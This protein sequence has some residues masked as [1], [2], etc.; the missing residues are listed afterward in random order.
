MRISFIK[1]D[2]QEER[3]EGPFFGGPET[4]THEDEIDESLDRAEAMILN[5]LDK[6]L[7]EGS[8]WQIDEI[9]GHYINLVAFK[10]LEGSSWLPSP[11]ELQNSAKGVINIKNDDNECLRWAH[12]RHLNPQAKN[13][14]R[15]K[16]SD[17]KMIDQLDYSGIQFPVQIKDI[18]RIEKQNKIRINVFGY[19]D[20]TTFPVS[21]S[22]EQFEDTLNLLLLVDGEKQHYALI[23]DFNRFMYQKTKHKA[24]KHFCENCLQNFTTG[25]QLQEHQTQ[26]KQ[27]QAVKMPDPSKGEHLLKFD[28]Y[29]RQVA[30]PFVIYCDTE[31][32]LE[33]IEQEKQNDDQSFTEAYQKHK[34]CGFGYKVACFYYDKYSKPVQIN[35]GNDAGKRFIRELHDEVQT[36]VKIATMLTEHYSKTE[37]HDKESVFCTNECVV[38]GNKFKKQENRGSWFC[39]FTGKCKGTAHRSCMSKAW[40]DPKK[41][42]IPIVFHNLKGYDSHFIIQ[43]LGNFINKQKNM[44]VSVIPNNT[45]KYMAFSLG[46]HMVFI[47][48]FQFMSSSLDKLV[49]N[50]PKDALK[51]TSQVFGDL[52]LELMTRKGVYPYDYMDSFEKFKEKKIP[53][54][55]AFYSQ[56][57]DEDISDEDYE[58][59]KQV[60]KAFQLKTLGGYHDLYLKSDVLLLADVFENFRRTCLDCYKLDPCHYFTSPG[61]AW[62]AALKMTKITLELL[63]DYDMY[64]FVERALRGGI[65]YIANRYG[66]A[67]NKYMKNFNPKEAIKYIMYLDANNLYGWAMCQHLPVGGFRW[68]NSA[69]LKKFKLNKYKADSKRG[70]FLEVDL[71]YPEKLHDL[72]NDYPCASEKLVVKQEW[73]SKYCQK[74]AAKFGI[75]VG[76]VHKLIPTLGSKNNYVLHYR[77]LQLYLDLGLVLVKIHRVL[78]FKQK[79]WLKQYIDFNTARRTAAKNAFEKDFYKLMNNSVFGKTMENLRKRVDVRLVTN[80]KKL[81][82]LTACPTFV[83]SSIINKDLVVVQKNHEELALNRPI[84]VGASILDLSKVLM[85]DFHYNYIKKKYNDKAKLLFTDTDSLCYEVETEDM[86]S[87]IWNDKEMFDFSDYSAESPFHSTENKKVIGKFKDEAAGIQITEF[88]GL[89]SKM[90]SYIKDNGSSGKTAKGIKKNVIKKCINHKNYKEVLENGLQLHHKMKTIRSVKHEISSFEINKVSLSC[91]DDKRYISDDGKTTLAYGHYRIG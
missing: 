37:N 59:V 25:N 33:K 49:S 79:P 46:D 77:N 31:A 9:T 64:L 44:K 48:S 69:E 14:Q 40:I 6:Y 70:C 27:V 60:W 85:Y 30:L 50:L 80:K 28:K 4:V 62:D 11:P 24:R 86:P 55:S 87:D 78:T 7:A 83:S 84:Y 71:E 51:Y 15:I 16:K 68:L 39:Q 42:R 54:K 36:C 45:E 12:I 72:H 2:P 66:K 88:V 61:L 89:R 91:F 26:C 1:Y 53:P 74:T 52:Q 67:N 32:V 41:I 38:C 47:D 43:E 35:R 57:T 3:S 81:L 10:P 29:Q 73:L 65:S 22:K 20:K 23:E 21:I 19:K 5:K 63:V 82:K 17:R 8:G 18:P 76:L 58:H 56:L 75:K 34:I 90:Y 13:P